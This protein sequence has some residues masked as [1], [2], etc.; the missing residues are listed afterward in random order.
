M[1]SSNWTVP[2]ERLNCH[3]CTDASSN[4]IQL[5]L[6]VW[7]IV[8]F[9]LWDRGEHGDEPGRVPQQDRVAVEDPRGNVRVERFGG[10]GTGAKLWA[11]FPWEAGRK[12]KCLVQAEGRKCSTAYTAWVFQS[13]YI[14]IY[15]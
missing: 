1:A 6:S 9:S 7:Q 13:L 14:D 3:G 8:L 11:D 5:L 4:V 10:E 2:T 12:I 15:I